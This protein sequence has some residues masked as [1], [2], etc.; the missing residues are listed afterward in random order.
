MGDALGSL[1]A[2]GAG[3]AIRLGAPAYLDPI[4][5]FL[6]VAILL[7]GALRLLRDAGLVLLE[8]APPRLPMAVVEK[9]ILKYPG[10]DS[11]H[12]LHVWSLGTGHEAV[13]VHVITESRDPNLGRK[14]SDH[15]RKT[16]KA[17]FVSV[18]VECDN[19]CL[20]VKAGA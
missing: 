20:S 17:E 4:G 12:A 3:L 5:S 6:V 14:L 18:Q 13:T 10:V 1:A 8:A 16:L 15:L 19:E 11:L 7:V 2:F 9:A